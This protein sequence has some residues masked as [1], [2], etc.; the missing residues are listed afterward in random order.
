MGLECVEKRSKVK[1]F[2]NRSRPACVLIKRCTFFLRIYLL[3]FSNIVLEVLGV[4]WP[5]VM[6]PSRCCPTI[7]APTFR[8][9]TEKRPDKVGEVKEALPNRG[10]KTCSLSTP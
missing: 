1:N 10:G 8:P 2:P 3:L 5:L 4:Q 7:A 6:Q 9:A